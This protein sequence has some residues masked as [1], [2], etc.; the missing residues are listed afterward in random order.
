M[1]YIFLWSAWLAA[2]PI[3][4][5]G[6]TCFF[7]LLQIFNIGTNEIIDVIRSVISSNVRLQPVYCEHSDAAGVLF[8]FVFI[9]D[10][11][12]VDFNRS[13]LLTLDRSLYLISHGFPYPGKCVMYAYGV[14]PSGS[15]S[16][17]MYPAVTDT[18][19]AT[20]R[21]K[22]NVKLLCSDCTSF[23]HTASHI[24]RA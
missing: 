23:T 15:F 4:L 10:S 11:G 3:I 12:G 9:I 7:L 5:V 20:G 24:Y 14:G 21:G 19:F 13:T 1:L 8:S 22:S 18:F 6:G 2:D 17:E 16:G